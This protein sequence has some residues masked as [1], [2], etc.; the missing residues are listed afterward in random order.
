MYSEYM[1][2]NSQICSMHNSSWYSQ[3]SIF[4]SDL[5]NKKSSEEGSVKQ[6][7]ELCFFTKLQKKGYFGD[8]GLGTTS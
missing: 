8:E 4:D 6:N 5:N 1:T 7:S 3:G 2:G